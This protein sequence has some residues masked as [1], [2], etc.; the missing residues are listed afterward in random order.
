VKRGAVIAAAFGGGVMAPSAAHADDA[1][2]RGWRAWRPRVDVEP[3]AWF[4][5]FPRVLLS[6][7]AYAFD[8][9]AMLM[10]MTGEDPDA[11]DGRLS[12]GAGVFAD[13]FVG[14]HVDRGWVVGAQ[15][16]MQRYEVVDRAT[17]E[18]HQ[19]D[20]AL[21][22]L[23]AGY[24]WHPRGLGGYIFPWVGAAITPEVGGDSGAYD[25]RPVVPYV[26]LDL[27]WRF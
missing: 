11:W 12:L 15:L 17:M 21:L 27:G 8:M 14:E 2:L 26:T 19:F 22:L 6:T 9:P 18:R 1:E 16:G 13:V 4:L 7:G 20:C 10:T 25:P 5:A 24:E 23:R 3:A